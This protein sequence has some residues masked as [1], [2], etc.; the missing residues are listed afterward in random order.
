MIPYVTPTDLLG[1]PVAP[2]NVTMPS[3]AATLGINFQQISE[4]RLW[5]MCGIAS[6]MCDTICGMTLRATSLYEELQ[7]PG[8]RLGM[9][10]DY[11]TRFLTSRKPI[12]QVISGQ[13]TYGGP[14]WT[15]VTIPTANLAPE[16]PVMDNFGS[17]AW[18]G[19]TSGQASILIGNMNL[20]AWGRKN[21]RIGLTY[22]SGWPHTGLLPAAKFSG[23]ITMAYP[24]STSITSIASTTGI[25]AG[26]PIY[27]EG[28]PANTTVVSVATNSIVISNAAAAEGT[29]TFTVGYPAGAT[30]LNVDDAT[31]WNVSGSV[32]GC[33]YD[34]IGT[35]AVQVI[36][37]T[38]DA[39]GL[40]T[41]EG[42]GVVT[43]STGTSF[44][45]SDGVALTTM[46]GN[47]RWATM[48]G[49]KIQALERGATA[50]TAQGTPGRGTTSGQG[51]M[52]HNYQAMVDLLK[53][54][55][56]VY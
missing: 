41:P 34:G 37:V 21:T 43:L 49:V 22:L 27:G 47:I 18:N 52:D 9:Q 55:R 24:S 31:A 15:W 40:A 42:P 16:Q 33:I 54:F 6:N 8:M 53:P 29:F 2:P 19:A 30:T 51:K 25:L 36:G 10:G 1:S 26:A 20:W 17:G 4:A 32:Y 39:V 46:P 23:V 56:R 12:L 11:V 28:I 35:E 7:G 13:M 45:H 44:P 3:D 48:L 14:P 5:E 50:I 38:S